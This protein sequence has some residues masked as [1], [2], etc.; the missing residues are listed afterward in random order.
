ANSIWEL[1]ALTTLYLHSVTLRCD[2]NA[3]K[4]VGFFS[5]CAN[6]KNL[7]LKSCNTKGFKGLSICLPLLSNLTLVDVDGSVKVF[8]IV[9]P[10]LK[11]LTIEGH[12]CLQLPANDYFSLEKAYISIFRPKDAHQVLCLLQQL[13]NVK[14]LTLNL[15]IVECLSS[16]VELMTNQPSPFANLKSLNI[17]P[18]REQV[19]GHGVKMS[20]EVKG[21]L[22]DSSSGAT[23]TMVTRED[24]K[25]MKD[26]KFAQEL[27]TELWELLEQEKARTETIMAKMHEQGRPQFS[28]CIGRDID[29][30]WKYTSARINKG[31]EKVS[32]ICYMLQNIKGS[33][34]EL[35]AS[36]QATIQPSFSTLCAE[37]DTVTNKITECIKMDCDENQRRINVCLHELATTLLPSS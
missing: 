28:E 6:L 24:I 9:A 37:V 35:P 32:D 31:K 21:Y 25:A 7:T 27:I 17:Y 34:K 36:N 14:F 18:I 4:Y 30:C 19:P 1:T 23:F 8:N 13:H 15:E 33:L 16:S 5:K 12:Y 10:Q 3:D 2:E 11:N 29:M 20:A 22:L 26:T